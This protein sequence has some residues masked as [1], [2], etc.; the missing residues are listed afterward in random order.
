[1]TPDLKA[2]DIPNG[3]KLVVLLRPVNKRV[4][5]DKLVSGCIE[6]LKLSSDSQ[7]LMTGRARANLALRKSLDLS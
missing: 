2:T 6:V 1:M 5:F 4:S 7:T 3:G